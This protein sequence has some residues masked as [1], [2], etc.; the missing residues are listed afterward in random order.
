MTLC[1]CCFIKQT[2]LSVVPRAIAV[3]FFNLSKL[4]Y[5]VVLASAVQRSVSAMCI[6]MSPPS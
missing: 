5:N 6:H 1:C 2:V 3:S 4:L